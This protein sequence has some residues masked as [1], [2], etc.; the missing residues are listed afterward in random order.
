MLWVT[1]D[2]ARLSMDQRPPTVRISTAGGRLGG[3]PV[4]GQPLD[5]DRRQ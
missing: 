5:P 3:L 2:L 1:L 4:R